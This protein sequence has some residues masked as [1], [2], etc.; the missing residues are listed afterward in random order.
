MRRG[1]ME[2]PITVLHIFSGDLWAGAEGVI[3]NLLERL[4]DEPDVNVVALSLN[5][6]ILTSKLRHAGIET[7]VISEAENSFGTILPKAVRILRTR[8]IG[9]IHSH[10]Y[11]ANLLAFLLAKF[12]AVKCLVTTLHGLCEPPIQGPIGEKGTHL[13]IKLDYFITNHFFN[14]IVAVSREIKNVLVQRYGFN[15]DTVDVIHN[16]IAVPPGLPSSRSS[17][18]GKFHIGTVG[19]MMPLKDF[20]L[21]LEVAA[22]VKKQADNVR[23][24]ILGDGPLRSE[25]IRK[26]AEL[27]IADCVEFLGAKADPFPYYK[28][29]DLYL[30]TSVHEGIPLSI[31]EAMAL[32]RAVVAPGVGGIPEIISHGEDGLLVDGRS[33]GE[34]AQLCLKLMEDRDLRTNIGNRAAKKVA[35][36]FSSSRMAASYLQLY[37]QSCVRG[38]S[39]GRISETVN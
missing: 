29:L 18:A 5:E 33:P 16:G 14:R 39:E 22:A 32:G 9:I 4:K 2:N 19:R 34:Y 13:Q 24:S 8:R 35:T 30:N 7:Y 27:K 1:S 25:L 38:E 28:S 6:G 36:Y 23:F 20:N 3:F 21:F 10:G 31:L 12:T 26:S 15:Q 17:A 37:T 11:K